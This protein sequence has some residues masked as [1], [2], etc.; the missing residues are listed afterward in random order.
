MAHFQWGWVHEARDMGA[1][2][3]DARKAVDLTQQDLANRLGVSRRTIIRMESGDE[4]TSVET[5]I[6]ALGECG[7][8]L[9]AIPR[10]ASVS[11]KT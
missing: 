3:R 6:L 9:A 2:V 1:V 5:A 11:V 4:G 10:N 8:E 7:V